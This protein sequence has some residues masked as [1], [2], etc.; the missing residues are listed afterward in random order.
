MKS[1]LYAGV[2]SRATP[3]PVLDLMRRCA[4]RLEVLGYTLRSGGANG[5]DTA[6]EE[7]CCRKELYLPWPGFNGRQSE[8]Q[9]V[10][11]KAL[12]LAASLHPRWERLSS[13]ARRL[14]A[15]NCYQILGTDLASPVDFVLCWTPDALPC[16]T[17]IDMD[18]VY[19]QDGQCVWGDCLSFVCKGSSAVQ[20]CF[21][22]GLGMPTRLIKHVWCHFPL[23]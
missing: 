5:A 12:A 1:M 4:T 7:G 23:C 2:G 19:V 21:S 3:E 9:T 8:F 17:N 22:W 18:P 11:N 10:C 15:R 20:E 14:M 6:F 13:P 16:T